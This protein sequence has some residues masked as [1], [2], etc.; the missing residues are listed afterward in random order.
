MYWRRSLYLQLSPGIKP[1]S[2]LNDINSFPQIF[3]C[4]IPQE[5]YKELEKCKNNQDVK[6][7]LGIKSAIIQSKEL[8]SNGAPAISFYTYGI[9]DNVKQIAQGNFLTFIKVFL[10]KERLFQIDK[11]VAFVKLKKCC[12]SIKH[13]PLH[14]PGIL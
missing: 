1:L 13:L 7:V 5:F 11:I 10:E 12:L 9:Y 8:I 3:S 2:T 4:D 6:E 14:Y